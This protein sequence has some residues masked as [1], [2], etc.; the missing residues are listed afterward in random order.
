[1]NHSLGWSPSTPKPIG[2]S[3]NISDFTPAWIYSEKKLNWCEDDQIK[4][5]PGRH[6]IYHRGVGLPVIH[7][8]SLNNSMGAY[9]GFV[10][11]EHPIWIPISLEGPYRHDGIFPIYFSYSNQV[12][13]CIMFIITFPLP[14]SLQKFHPVRLTGGFLEG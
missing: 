8:P 4:N 7:T 9:L 10:V 13:V 5:G 2:S 3:I 14:N 12:L 1:M 6:P 11:D